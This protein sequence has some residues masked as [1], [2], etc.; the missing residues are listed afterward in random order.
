[1]IE[2]AQSEDHAWRWRISKDDIW[3]GGYRTYQE[4]LDAATIALAWYKR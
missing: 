3:I 4:A 1:M 2:I